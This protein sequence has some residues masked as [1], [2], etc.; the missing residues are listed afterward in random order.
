MLKPA[1]LKSEFG[2]ICSNDLT[3][4]SVRIIEAPIITARRRV[5]IRREKIQLFLQ[6][7]PVRRFHEEGIFRARREQVL[8]IAAGNEIAAEMT[9]ILQSALRPDHEQ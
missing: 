4:I 8:I 1:T 7:E 5:F 2:D 6:T 9:I 3:M